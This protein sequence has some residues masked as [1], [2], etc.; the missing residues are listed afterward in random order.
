M[1]KLVHNDRWIA[2]TIC[3]AVVL[4]TFPVFAVGAE[5][6]NIHQARQILAAT[7][8]NG[9]LVVHFGCGDGKLTA[10]LRANDSYRMHGLDADPANID[11]A[12]RHLQ[13]LGLYGPV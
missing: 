3:C 2:W 5:L 12:R 6:P 4:S 9:G 11:Q 13:T 10:A 7:G 8:V 1:I